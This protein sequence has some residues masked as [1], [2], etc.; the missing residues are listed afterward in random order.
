VFQEGFGFKASLLQRSGPFA[1]Q[2]YI[3]IH[4]EERALELLAGVVMT[5]R[6]AGRKNAPAAMHSI[7]WGRLKEARASYLRALAILSEDAR[8]GSKLGL[9][10]VRL[11]L[12][13]NGLARLARAL[14]A[15]ADEWEMHDRM[16][17]GCI[18][19]NLM[20]EAAAAAERLAIEHPNPASILR[21][22]AIR[23]QM[24]E[25][26]AA[27]DGIFEACNCFRRIRSYSKL[28]TS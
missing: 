13:K 14:Q 17:K 2:L 16:I 9:T 25:W 28:R 12:K 27:E 8:I 6:A 20:P 10:E 5:G 26:R 23:A 22:A 7:T 19:A 24:K 15:N 4:A 11:G 1:G 18:L 3:D 21:A